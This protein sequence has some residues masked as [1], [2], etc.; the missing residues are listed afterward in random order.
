MGEKKLEVMSIRID[1]T[2]RNRIEGVARG[3]ESLAGIAVS[4][5]EVLRKAIDRGLS[6][7]ERE[8]PGIAVGASGPSK[9]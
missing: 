4:R 3:F 8:R 7:L 5:A 9:R 1:T 6:E 2:L